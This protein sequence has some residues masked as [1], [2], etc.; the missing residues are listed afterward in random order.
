MP[1]VL[2]CSM[3][4]AWIFPDEATKGST[5]LRES[6]LEDYALVPTVWP[7]EVANVLLV[8]TR[9]KRVQESEWPKLLADLAVLPIEVDRE[10]SERALSDG[11][12]V[13]RRY[14]LSAYDA[15]YLELALRRKAPIATLDK[16]LKSACRRAGVDVL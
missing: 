16:N 5:A 14:D 8:A 13:A 4:M 6:L 15:V 12:Q 10:T 7:L 2:D 3:T 9:R 1:F 11:L